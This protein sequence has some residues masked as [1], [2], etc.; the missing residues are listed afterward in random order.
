MTMKLSARA[1][2]SHAVALLSALVAVIAFHG[3]AA[4]N[5]NQPHTL[6]GVI[7]PGGTLVVTVASTPVTTDADPF[8]NILDLFF[9]P[10]ETLLPSVGA[11]SPELDLGQGECLGEFEVNSPVGGWLPGAVLTFNLFSGVAPAGAA[12]TDIYLTDDEWAAACNYIAIV[13]FYTTDE[14]TNWLR[15]SCIP[16]PVSAPHPMELV[17]TPDPVVPGG[18][19]TCVIT[20]GDPGIDILWRASFGGSA[21]VERGVT[22]D[23]DGRGTFT[24][25]AP[26]A[27][28]DQAIL[29]ELVEWNPAATVQVSGVPLPTRL[30]AGEGSGALPLGLALGA[31][32]LSGAAVLRLRRAGAVS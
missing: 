13:S 2:R 23:A 29:V 6:S 14:W 26:L 1:R 31:L 10:D 12:E 32:V 24:F 28:R 11:G 9:C 27:A 20:Q 7:R 5:G 18:T 21:F 19:V 16:E 15:A 8:E 22:L 17:C 30:P 3:P 25:V 4:A